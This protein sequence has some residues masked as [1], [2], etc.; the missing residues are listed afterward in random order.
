MKSLQVTGLFLE[1]VWLAV[2]SSWEHLWSPLRVVCSQ[3]KKE[4]GGNRK[5]KTI[6]HGLC[7]RCFYVT[8]R[9]TLLV[10]LAVLSL[11]LSACEHKGRLTQAGNEKTYCDEHPSECVVHALDTEARP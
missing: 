10:A 4:L 11:G 1:A 6:S 5:S 7:A 2:V 3:C 8:L 9:P